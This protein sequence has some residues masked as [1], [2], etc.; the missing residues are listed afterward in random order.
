MILEKIKIFSNFIKFEH[1]LFALPFALSAYLLVIK[2][3]QFNLTLLLL[4]I[5]ALISAR[6]YGMAINRIIDSNYTI[7][8]NFTEL[9]SEYNDNIKLLLQYIICSF[10]LAF[11]LVLHNIAMWCVVFPTLACESPVA[12]VGSCHFLYILFFFRFLADSGKN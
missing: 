11:L 5:V 9:Y 10:I 3:N 8:M 2:N 7:N 12:A 6:T 4:I 1:S